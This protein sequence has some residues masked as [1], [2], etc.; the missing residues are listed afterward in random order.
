[1]KLAVFGNGGLWSLIKNYLDFSTVDIV[2]FI[3]SDERLLGTYIDGVRVLTPEKLEGVEFDYLIFA[4]KEYDKLKSQ[5]NNYE[6]IKHKIIA[7]RV[8]ESQ[9][10]N[11]LHQNLNNSLEEIRN[12]KKI[13]SVS[14]FPNEPFFLC[15]YPLE[16]YKNNIIKYDVKID[17]V[18]LATLSLLSNEVIESKVEGEVAELGVYQGDFA[19]YINEYFPDKKLYLF[20]TF[21]GF[22]IEDVNYD[23]KMGFSELT[24]QFTDTGLELVLAKM[25]NK[26]KCIGK[27]GYFPE[28]T[29]GF[30]ERYSFVSIDTDLYKP[31]IEGL[32]YFYPR[33]SRGGY[34]MIHDY[35]NE[36][37][38]GVKV[39][40]K[41]YCREHN[42]PYV[43][44]VDACGSIIIAK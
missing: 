9:P 24:T 42:I 15:K 26:D 39:A 18:R 36:I 44:V 7:Y 34:I 10:F 20:D 31:I 11:E 40:V 41:E 22:N 43:P 6:E 2:A 19:K 1:M 32:K 4:S 33:L 16:A 28:T 3:N 25:K 37:F 12:M 5:L 17:S 8:E 38:H 29:K 27:V 23:L 30:E 35:N 13:G 14:S 21:K